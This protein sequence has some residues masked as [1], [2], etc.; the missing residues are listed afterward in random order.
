MNRTIPLF[1][2][3]MS[4]KA[5]ENVAAVLAS[6][7][8]GQGPIVEEFEIA[9]ANYFMVEAPLTLNSATSGLTLALRL[10]TDQLGW[11][12]EVLAPPITCTA[13]NW[14]ILA[15]SHQIRWVDTNPSDGNMDLDDL[16]RKIGPKTATIMLVHW[17]GY[18]NDLD[19][20]REIQD[21]CLREYGHRPAV[22]EDA[23]H[24]MGAEYKGLRI[25]SHGNFCVFS[26]QA[27]KHL[28]SGDGGVLL[29]P[30]KGQE[31]KARLLRWYG[32]DR[33]QTEN[34]RC[35][36]DILDWG[37]KFHMNDINA[38]IGL[39]NFPLVEDTVEAHRANASYFRGE[40]ASVPGI[41]LLL[42]EVDRQS[43]Y[44]LFTIRAERRDDLQKRLAGK[45]IEAGRV[46]E[47]NDRYA[48]TIPFRDDDL[49]GTDT[50]Q[51]EMLCIP[52]GWWV[53]TEDREYI[54]DVIKGGW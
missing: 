18:P 16:Q 48:C 50:L 39:A 3:R 31:E 9:L 36:N 47:R 1:R 7:Y 14:P 41:K 26:L 45:G 35:G 49:P 4:E 38:A 54:V 20:V 11:Q 23:S 15:L 29:C 2:V 44:W 13:T 5:A 24:A 22:I 27:I 40:L 46:H 33:R 25:G 52:V 17:G 51:K 8:I 30:N 10:V 19:R 53:S 6:G 43:S 37:Y 42:E 28:T 21:E 32:I 12:G 34:L